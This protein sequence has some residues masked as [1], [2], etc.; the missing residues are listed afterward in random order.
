VAVDDRITVSEKD[1]ASFDLVAN[2]TD[3][4]GDRLTLIS[5]AV[6]AVTGLALTSE[7]AAAAF[8]VVDGKLVVDPSSAFAALEDDQQAVVTLTYSVRDA[9][10]GEA[11]GTTT[12]TV[13]GY[14]EYTIVS[15][16]DG[17]DVL[18]AGDGKD[19]LEGGDGNDT[20]LAGAGNDMVDA[21]AG[22]DRVVAGDGNDIVE[23]GAG[24]DVLMGGAGNDVLHG[25]AGNDQ[26]N[27]GSGDDTLIGGAGNDVLTG[28][29]GADTFV[30][31]AG[32]GRDVVTDFQAGA[33][34][35]D[36]V[37]LSKD[38][39][40]DYQA[41][42]ASGVFTDGDHGAEIA[43]KDGSTITFDGVKTEQ[44]VIDDF[45]FA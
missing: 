22:N 20:L 11:H 6:A 16:T 36:V 44:F 35:K 41:F 2:D 7:Q 28:G 5:V 38:V 37:E 21:G 25:G 9:N 34:G 32:S 10:G 43:F 39:F 15:G 29:S 30:F 26:L 4:E 23:G 19:M 14:T 27:G 33:D 31:A 17:N 12:V 3:V 24:N 13:D 42:I 40:A 1:N 45:R 18:V 8:S